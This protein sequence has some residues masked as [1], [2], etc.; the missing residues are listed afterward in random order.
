MAAAYRY[1]DDAVEE[2][3]EEWMEIVR[4]N[5]NHPCI[6]TWTPFNESWGI[7]RV[8]TDRKQ[9]HFTEAIYHLTKSFDAN[10]PVIVNDGWEHTVSDII[11][12]HNYEEKERTCSGTIR[13]DGRKSWQGRFPAIQAIT[14][15]S[16]TV[17]HTG[18]SRF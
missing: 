7:G 12:L 4:Q 11:T 8:K 9:Q 14:W 3:T 5:Y 16:R 15:L 6:I 17:I 2:F 13:S 1:G 10:R 18:D